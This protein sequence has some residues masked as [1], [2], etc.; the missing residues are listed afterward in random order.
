MI[1][2][3]KV[4]CNYVDLFWLNDISAVRPEKISKMLFSSGD[5]EFFSSYS[6]P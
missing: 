2:K 6:Q 3:Q 5:S 1:V 4:G